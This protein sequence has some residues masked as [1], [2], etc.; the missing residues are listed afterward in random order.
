MLGPSVDLSSGAGG[1][2]PD[3]P[4]DR[5]PLLGESEKRKLLVGWNETAAAS[6]DKLIHEPFE[7]QVRRTP[8][9]VAG[10]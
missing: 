7:E 4:I 10:D 6:K 5:L 2:N 9:A 3:C 1:A 8:Q